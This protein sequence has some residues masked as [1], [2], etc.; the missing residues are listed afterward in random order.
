M[1]KSKNRLKKTIVGM[2]TF[3]LAFFLLPFQGLFAAPQEIKDDTD[4]SALSLYQFQLTTD[5]MSVVSKSSAVD[6]YHMNDPIYEGSPR[7]GTPMENFTLKVDKT[8]KA[9][10]TFDKPFVFEIYQCWNSQW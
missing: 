8:K 10:Q 2:I 5:N 1:I 3:V 4:L 7:V 6:Q 9:D